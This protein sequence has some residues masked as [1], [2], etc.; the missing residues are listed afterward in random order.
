[1]QPLQTTGLSSKHSNT[2]PL[3]SPAT[4]SLLSPSTEPLFSPTS[5]AGGG[6]TPRASEGGLLGTED[7]EEFLG[8]FGGLGLPREEEGA[9]DSSR[10]NRTGGPGQPHARLHQ[11]SGQST[12]SL[13]P[14]PTYDRVSLSPSQTLSSPSSLPPLILVLNLNHTLLY[15]SSRTTK[16]S[17]RPTYRPFLS[18]FLEWVY[19]ANSA[20]EDE[21]DGRRKIEVLVYTATRAHN[22]RTLLEGMGL[23]TSP[24]SYLSS[25]LAHKQSS[26]VNLLLSREDFDLSPSDYNNDIDTVKDLSRVWRKIG[27]SEEEGARRTVLLSDDEGDAVL[28]PYSHLPIPPFVP[29]LS[30]LSTDTSLLRTISALSLLSHETNVAGFIRSGGLEKVKGEASEE[31]G[32]RVCEEAGVR[33]ERAFDEGG[34]GGWRGRRRRREELGGGTPEDRK[35]L[36]RLKGLAKE[37]VSVARLW[38]R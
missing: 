34:G 5:A 2:P 37:E 35:T 7:W 15:R 13:K 16:G 18:T 17:K 27:I 10:R 1:M 4:E 28:Q 29:S 32:R 25:P 30:S 19:Q 23:L 14:S 26:F 9:A 21:G 31:R 36:D 22:A 38:N 11:P 33:V 6:D 12:T 20:K 3:V 24:Y 8:R